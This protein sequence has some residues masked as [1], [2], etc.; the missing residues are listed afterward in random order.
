MVDIIC[1]YFIP[2]DVASSKNS[3]QIVRQG[4]FTRLIDSKASIN[5]K[6]KSLRHYEE[7]A[8]F[9]KPYMEK[10]APPYQLAFTFWRKTNR[11][12]DYVNLAQGPL[13]LMTKVG[14]YEDDNVRFCKPHFFDSY[15]VKDDP[16]LWISLLSGD[17]L[18]ELQQTF[19]NELTTNYPMAD[20]PMI[21]DYKPTKG[22]RKKTG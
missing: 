15:A 10:L 17:P 20:Y 11:A 3:K 6:A 7:A 12:F 18:I 8:I 21:N 22:N 13:D 14:I 16:G 19:R 9:F 1:S 2:E 4:K 5:Y